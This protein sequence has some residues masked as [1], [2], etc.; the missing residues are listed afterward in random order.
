MYAM[1]N[2]FQVTQRPVRVRALEDKMCLYAFHMKLII[3]NSYRVPA[4]RLVN[5]WRTIRMENV[6]V[7]HLFLLEDKIGWIV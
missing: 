3:R 1:T 7:C 6:P 5:H 2:G 4:G